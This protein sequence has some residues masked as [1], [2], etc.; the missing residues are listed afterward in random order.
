MSVFPIHSSALFE[1]NLG[2]IYHLMTPHFY[3][4]N[5]ANE[6]GVGTHYVVLAYEVNINGPLNELPNDQHYTYKW[7]KIE[8]LLKEDEVHPHT[9]AYFIQSALQSDV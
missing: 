6:P 4:E 3:K 9:K 2:Q 7:L 5:F 1:K 8:S